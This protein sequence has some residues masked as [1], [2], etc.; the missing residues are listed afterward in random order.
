[1]FCLGVVV[2]CVLVVFCFGGGVRGNGSVKKHA[3]AICGY[4]SRN[5]GLTSVDRKTS[6]LSYVQYP[7]SAKSSTKDLSI[8]MPERR[9]KWC[10]PGG[11]RYA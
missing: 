11:Y 8:S 6:L 9:M 4:K 7:V 3:R 5:P 10:W 1:M 2:F